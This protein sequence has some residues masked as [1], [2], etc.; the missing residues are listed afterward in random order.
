MIVP[1]RGG[2]IVCYEVRDR[3]SFISLAKLLKR[4]RVIFNLELHL[5]SEAK[6]LLQ[7]PSLSA[8][9]PAY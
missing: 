1:L 8:C 6:G 3:L 9:E 7:C 4:V 2:D 5:E